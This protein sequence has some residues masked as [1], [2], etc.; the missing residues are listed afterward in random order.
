MHFDV[1][2]G[3]SII[4]YSSIESSSIVSFTAALACFQVLEALNGNELLG[5]QLFQ[6]NFLTTLSGE[7]LVTMI[8]HK[9]LDD[10]WT[11]QARALK[12]RSVSTYHRQWG[13]VHKW[14]HRQWGGVHDW[15]R[16]APV[17][18]YCEHQLSLRGCLHRWFVFEY[19]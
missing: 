16:S 9:K 2:I 14:Y 17:V 10:A 6:V 7:A 4:Y 19:C 15:Y 11:E 18:L 3:S 12:E 13:G 1:Q 8:Y 5:K